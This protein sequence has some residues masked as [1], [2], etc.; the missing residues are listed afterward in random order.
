MTG[1]EIVTLKPELIEPLTRMLRDLQEAGDERDFHPH[2]LVEDAVRDI[3]ATS[4]RDQYYLV[5]EDGDVL[6]YGMLRGWDEGF[7]VPG[8]GIAVSPKARGEGIGLLLVRFL[9]LAA[10]RAGASRVRLTVNV[11]NEQARRL[12]ESVGY[13]FEPYEDRLLG[14]VTL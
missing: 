9:H 11:D 6:A 8:L 4:R 5:L 1:I 2:P 3:V 7:E 10:K 14:F 12:Y 13:T